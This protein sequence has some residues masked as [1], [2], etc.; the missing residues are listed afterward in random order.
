MISAAARYALLIP[1]VA[2]AFVGIAAAPLSEPDEA[3]YA[4]I[5]R[6]MLE[7]GDWVTPRLN[8][9]PYF[10]KP[11]LVYWL[12]AASFAAFGERELSARLVVVVAALLGLAVTAWVAGRLFGE[13][14][15]FFAA[16]LLGTSPLYFGLGHALTLDLPVAM[17]VTAAT[18]CFVV[19]IVRDPPG[20]GALLVGGWAA[21]ALATLTKG[22]IGLALPL[23]T[24]GVLLVIARRWRDLFGLEWIR[25]GLLYSAI[26]LPWFVAVSLRNPRFL[27]FFFVHE[28]LMRYAS[29]VH[30]RTG[31][32]WYYVPVVLAG[33]LPWS[34]LA[35][36]RLA[37][38]PG[39]RR[40]GGDCATLACIVWAAVP[41]VLFSTAGSKLP[42]YILPSLPP[43]AILAAR[44]QEA[45]VRCRGLA[46]WTALVTLAAAVAGWL[47]VF[48]PPIRVRWWA[49]AAP[50]VGPAAALLAAAAGASASV[51]WVERRFGSLRALLVLAGEALAILVMAASWRD[52]LP[53][54]RGL[55]MAVKA[56]L[57]PGARVVSYAHYLQAIPFYAH[58]RESVV[59][60]PG[61]LAF[62]AGLVGDGDYHWKTDDRLVAE[63]A[64][65]DPLLLIIKPRDLERLAP[66]LR[67]APRIVA[68]F[69][70]RVVAS[71]R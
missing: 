37:S 41:F 55:A 48:G 11:P 25:G 61:E 8:G 71:N 24:A 32:L 4:E 49:D 5:G 17:L 10:E 9:L 20:R 44:A 15:R 28:H 52:L 29:T 69:E 54:E 40:I 23:A 38:R 59:H 43:L 70:R 39:A 22:L 6:E 66:R 16:V 47:A 50:V 67:P 45:L 35:I 13:D 56:S 1:L 14:T 18:G 60:V 12:T 26:V 21:A 42:G 68:R 64:K 7:S 46:A 27:W 58:V 33:T 62:G 2:S 19:A 30:E 57:V 53:N 63:W 31:P 34:L 51:L 3:R 65:P 36:D